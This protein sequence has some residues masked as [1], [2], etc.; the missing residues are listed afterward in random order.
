M[1]NEQQTDSHVKSK[2]KLKR[3]ALILL[4]IG[5]PLAITGG[6][7]F[8]FAFATFP[9]NHQLTPIGMGVLAGG[10][11]LVLPSIFLLFMAHQREITKYMVEETG[12][13]MGST[14]DEALDG[15]GRVIS[16]GTEAM[17]SGISK[18]GG[19]KLDVDTRSEQK[20]MVKCRKCGTLNDEDA[21][22]CDECGETI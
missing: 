7:L 12:R 1:K 11:F 20:I 16:R 17:A 6:I 2:K 21:K 19:I 10:M 3:I 22:F 18:A 15:L 9:E 4:G 8:G 13:A 14:S 5:I